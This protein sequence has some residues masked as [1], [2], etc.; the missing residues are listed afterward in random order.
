M[1]V[2]LLSLQSQERHGEPT[3]FHVAI[4]YFVITDQIIT[5]YITFLFLS[6]LHICNASGQSGSP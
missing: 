2:I 5:D 6:I 3:S 4:S 1:V